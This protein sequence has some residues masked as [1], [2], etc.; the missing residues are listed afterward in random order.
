MTQ[1][2]FRDKTPDN[3]PYPK[4]ALDS[5]QRKL[6]DETRTAVLWAQPSFSDIW[7]AMMVDRDGQTAWFTDQVPIAATNDRFMFLNPATFFKY[8]LEQRVFICLHEILHCTFNHCAM[9]WNW[10][11]AGKIDYADGL[12]LPF[13]N[14]LMQV[15]ADCVINA[16]LIE[17]A[18]GEAPPECWHMPQQIP[19]KMNIADAYRVLYK[20]SKG[21]GGSGNKGKGGPPRNG[22]KS[23]EGK[24]FDEHMKPG[25]GNGQE[26]TEAVAERNPQQWINAINAA[27]ESARLAG[28]LPLNLERMFCSTMEVKTD[29]RELLALCLS[30]SIGMEGHSWQFLNNEMATRGIGFPARVRHGCNRVVVIADTSGSVDQKTMDY[31]MSNLAAIVADAKPRQTTFAQCDT[32]IH[33]WEDID[34]VEE[35]DG[36][37]RGGGGTDFRP[38]FERIATEDDAPD[39]LVYLTDLYGPFPETPPS[40]PVIWACINKEKAPW[41]DTIHIP[42][43][44]SDEELRSYQ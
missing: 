22:N 13:H 8:P 24:A 7:Y 26:P 35:L 4:L 30:K 31:F 32:T 34:G 23:G 11:M 16:I 41:G 40:Y 42:P 19:G 27:M 10:Q 21:K 44:A 33:S 29:W 12:S 39:V 25:E 1:I 37:V 3:S 15:A 43:L 6:W 9:F 5:Q 18:C 2:P 17:G 14:S 28:K 20:Q 38:P 36:K